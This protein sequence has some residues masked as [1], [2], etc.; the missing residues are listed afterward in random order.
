MERFSV[1]LRAKTSNENRLN[2]ISDSGRDLLDNSLLPFRLS[3]ALI[4]HRCF[5][6]LAW[7]WPQTVVLNVSQVSIATELREAAFSESHRFRSQER[8]DAMEFMAGAGE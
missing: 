2:R 8:P 7:A 1:H 4:P 5:A 6:S 3:V